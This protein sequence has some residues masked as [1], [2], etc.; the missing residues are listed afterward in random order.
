MAHTAGERWPLKLVN[1]L[2][3]VFFFSSSLYSV[4]TPGG[5]PKT[6][7]ITPAAWG[8]YVWT[9]IDILLLGL[10][11][12]QFTDAGYEPVIEGLG[13]RFAIIGV[14][15]AVFVWL[16]HHNHYIVGFIFSILLAAA[17]SETYWQL[18]AKHQP[19]SGLAAIF[20]HLP[21]SLWHAYAVFTMVIAGAQVF[22]KDALHQKAGL[23]TK[24]AAV[25]AIAFLT[26]T[27]VGYAFHSGR[28]DVA[29]AAVIA[30]E[31]LAIFTAHRHPAVIHW[32][33]LA[34]FII[35]TLACLKALFFSARSG[36]LTDD[37][38]AP[39]IAGQNA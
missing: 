26:S 32:F 2:V 16:N 36:S 34:G 22:G 38:R 39:L 12:V 15:N 5:A 29:G 27:S 10:V 21:F 20:V 33:A 6:T 8:T 31:L 3:F 13:F 18:K 35:S 4:L 23:A 25:V 14:L 11:V 1:V 30:F 28:G 9:L 19:K 7:Y 24:I 17:V 37:E